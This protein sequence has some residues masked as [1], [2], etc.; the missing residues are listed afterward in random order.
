MSAHLEDTRDPVFGS[1]DAFTLDNAAW[2]SLTGPH[3]RFAEVRGD[4]V[5]YPIDVAPFVA[6]AP[7]P[8][9]GVWDDLAALV[10]PG[11]AVVAPNLA[12]D[13]PR[14]WATLG[15]MEVVQMVA[16]GLRVEVDPE[17]VRLE[18]DDV[19]EMLALVERTKPGPFR[20]RTL[21]LGDYYGIRRSG[22]LIAMAGE[23]LHPP[24]FSE[25]SAVCT[26]ADHRGQGL[27]TR[28]VRTV[29]AGIRR[30]GE[31]PFLHAA[32]NNANAIRLYASIGFTLRRRL[33]F[34][35]LQVPDD[36]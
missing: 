23:R 3:A 7:E 31:T 5:R 8:G 30:R 25:I 1:K 12:L 19:P 4:A 24:G 16:T 14:D 32:G 27:A 26:D 34:R 18:P 2:T 28:L 36:E 9:S 10:G 17:A 22:T 20:P 29:A 6:V 33:T 21:E 35:L 11:G 13:P 15:E